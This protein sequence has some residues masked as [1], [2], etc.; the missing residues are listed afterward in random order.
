CQ[1]EYASMHF[2][3]PTLADISLFDNLNDLQMSVIVLDV[4]GYLEVAGHACQLGDV[5]VLD[6]FLLAAFE[7]DR[8]HRPA[9]LV[10]VADVPAQIL[11][12][13]RCAIEVE[14]AVLVGEYR[15][16]VMHGRS[17]GDLTRTL[18]QVVVSA[19]SER[20]E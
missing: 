7:Q 18:L 15:Q 10:E 2:L 11:R 19:G 5:R 12:R 6:L 8:L 3:L 4:R 17:S 13:E 9:R 14:G 1:F 16:I 20:A